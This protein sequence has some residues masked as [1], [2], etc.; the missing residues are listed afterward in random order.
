MPLFEYSALDAKGRKRTGFVDAGGLQAARERLKGE[1]LFVVSL[2]PAAAAETEASIRSLSLFGRVSNSDLALVT[3]QLATL[4]KA[5]LPLVQSLEAL[6]EQ[7]EKPAVRKVLSS[8]RNHVN[9]G[10]ALH[11]AL[12]EH[13]SVFPPLFIQM[14]RAGEAGGFLEAIMLRLAETL[15]RDI[16]LRSRVL[17]ALVYPIIMT[18][19]GFVF[20]LFL[21]AYVVPQVVGIFEDFGRTLPLP[22]RVLLFAS[23][24]ASRFWMP[25]VFGV[26]AGIIV[27]RRLSKSQR[28]GHTVDSVKLKLPLFGRLSLKMAS[29]RMCNIL[30]SL[31]KS[32]VPM[33]RALEIVSEVLGNRLLSRAVQRSSQSVAQGGTL[34]DS[35]RA[36]GVFPP[37]IPR[38]VA[39]GEQS[40]QLP[41][42]LSGVAESFEQEVQT[43]I[44]ALTSILEPALIL[45]M[46]TVVLFVVLAVLL[47]IFE[48]NQLVRSG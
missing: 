2:D 14:S 39:V 26:V 8:V 43:S 33:I 40:G 10:M 13:P 46:A 22:T 28:F 1:G 12:S 36:S 34:A 47:P 35:I 15:E 42:M 27:Y 30:A 29:A 21:F 5:G 23:D 32:G 24:F 19:M 7:V 4:L 44:Q 45:V 3:R 18:V 20:L 9:E 16:R 41:D 6:I 17:A 38:V 11:E 25:I 31:L 48:L 37:L